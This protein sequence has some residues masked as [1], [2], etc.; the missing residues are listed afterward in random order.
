MGVSMSCTK[1]SARAPDPPKSPRKRNFAVRHAQCSSY[2][3]TWEAGMRTITAAMLSLLVVGLAGNVSAASKKASKGDFSDLL[4]AMDKAPAK[5]ARHAARTPKQ[6]A[7]PK[8][9]HK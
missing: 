7:A 3:R 4:N 1:W 2:L 5:S 9:S 8:P 6:K